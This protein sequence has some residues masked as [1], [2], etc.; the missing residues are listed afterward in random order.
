MLKLLSFF[1]ETEFELDQAGSRIE[2]LLSLTLKMLSIFLI[3]WLWILLILVTYLEIC[4]ALVHDLCLNS[5][6]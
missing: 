6:W 2:I 5:R 4:I 1:L 3:S